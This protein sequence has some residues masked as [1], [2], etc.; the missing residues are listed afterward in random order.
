MPISDIPP[1]LDLYS[2]IK[3]EL[4]RA[5]AADLADATDPLVQAGL[6]AVLAW[7][8]H[9][10]CDTATL[11]ELFGR[12]HGPLGPQLRLMGSLLDGLDSSDWG[13][14]PPLWWQVVQAAY[15]ARWLELTST[16]KPT[17]PDREPAP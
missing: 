15:Y 17:Q 6:H 12:P 7:L 4:W 8:R 3:L 1:R 11:L 5:A 9:D 10:A 16:G 13:Q 14:L 2:R